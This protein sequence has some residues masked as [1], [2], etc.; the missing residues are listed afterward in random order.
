MLNDKRG[1]FTE[2][3]KQQSLCDFPSGQSFGSGTFSIKITSKMIP[4]RCFEFNLFSP[5]E[6]VLL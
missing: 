2:V 1:F 3:V 6:T 5:K 4:I